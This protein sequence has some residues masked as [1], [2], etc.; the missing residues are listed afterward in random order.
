M[1]LRTG[2]GSFLT[3]VGATTIIAFDYIERVVQQA[4]ADG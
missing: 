4:R 2:S 3:R 1:S